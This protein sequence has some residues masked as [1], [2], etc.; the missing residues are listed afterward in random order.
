MA[1]TFDDSIRQRL[2]FYNTF[3]FNHLRVLPSLRTCRKLLAESTLVLM[4][5]RVAKDTPT[6]PQETLES[7]LS[8]KDSLDE[9]P[10]V[11][12]TLSVKQAKK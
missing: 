12:E 9:K 6:E 3:F 10:V 7:L 1:A 4:F 2:S 5:E 11:T 8:Q